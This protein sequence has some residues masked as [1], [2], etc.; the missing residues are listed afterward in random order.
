[1]AEDSSAS[2]SSPPLQFSS[3]QARSS[4]TADDTKPSNK[5]AGVHDDTGDDN[6]TAAGKKGETK[7]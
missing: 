3:L 6:T 7:G 4:G 2:P 1:M 5:A